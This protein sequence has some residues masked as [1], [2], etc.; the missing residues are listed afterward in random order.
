MMDRNSI[1]NPSL[2]AAEAD[3]S[4]QHKFLQPRTNALIGR[5]E[6]ATALMSDRSTTGGPKRAWIVM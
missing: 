6:V 5:E 4:E 2:K 1:G 3:V